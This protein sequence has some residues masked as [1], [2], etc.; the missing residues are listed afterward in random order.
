MRL[1]LVD[2][3]EATALRVLLRQA[4]GYVAA[5]RAERTPDALP[6]RPRTGDDRQPTPGLKFIYTIA[7]LER[8]RSRPRSER[9]DLGSRLQ[10]RIRLW[11]SSTITNSTMTSSKSS[12]NYSRS[13]SDFIDRSARP[14]D[15]RFGNATASRPGMVVSPSDDEPAVFLRG[16]V[17]PQAPDDP[18]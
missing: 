1:Q 3:P 11:T 9:T 12:G 10:S 7:R 5:P 15:Q 6:L 18:R 14:D 17:R 13:R 8:T 16:P 2:V 4:A